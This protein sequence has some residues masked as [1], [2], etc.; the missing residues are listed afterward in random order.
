MIFGTQ[1]GNVRK[2]APRGSISASF[3]T[4]A[5][6]ARNWKCSKMPPRR[7]DFMTFGFNHGQKCSKKGSQELVQA[8]LKVGAL[9][10]YSYGRSHTRSW[11]P[12]YI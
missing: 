3:V 1:A 6:N 7:L 5:G 11:G 10:I 12:V 4:Q 8:S 9:F 2:G